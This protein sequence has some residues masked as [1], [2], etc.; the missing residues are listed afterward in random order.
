MTKH[1]AWG[2][3]GFALGIVVCWVGMKHVVSEK[4]GAAYMRGVEDGFWASGPIRDLH[5]GRMP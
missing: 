4:E 1:A 5:N 3:M 2:I